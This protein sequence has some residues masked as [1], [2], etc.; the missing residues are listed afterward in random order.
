MI[1]YFIICVLAFIVG[2]VGTIYAY[3]KCNKFNQEPLWLCLTRT[4]SYMAFGY[5]L[6]HMLGESFKTMT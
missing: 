5:T 2:V 1:Y 6:G 4:I 3:N